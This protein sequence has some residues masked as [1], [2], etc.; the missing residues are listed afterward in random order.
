MTDPTLFD[1]PAP[2]R[3][4]HACAG[5]QC[6]YCTTSATPKAAAAAGQADAAGKQWAWTQLARQWVQELPASTFFTADDLTAA[7]G[8][9]N[10][11]LSKR[12]NNAVGAVFAALSRAHVIQRVRP[13]QAQRKSS[14]GTTVWEWVRL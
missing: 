12:G 6:R 13:V 14:H 7:V 2:P 8:L 3:H 1:A 9:P 10:A 4:L 5:T 11:D